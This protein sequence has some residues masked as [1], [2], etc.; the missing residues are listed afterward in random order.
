MCSL[1]WTF[2]TIRLMCNKARWFVPTATMN[3]RSKMAFPICFWL[4]MRFNHQHRY[5]PTQSNPPTHMQPRRSSSTPSFTYA[6]CI[7][8]QRKQRDK[9]YVNQSFSWFGCVHHCINGEGCMRMEAL[10]SMWWVLINQPALI[11]KCFFI[12]LTLHRWNDLSHVHAP[13]LLS[14]HVIVHVQVEYHDHD[15]IREWN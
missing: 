13:F 6:S 3:T 10:C 8:T 12:V 1:C 2:F 11:K 4:S 15:S 14:I 5:Q 7:Y 9:K